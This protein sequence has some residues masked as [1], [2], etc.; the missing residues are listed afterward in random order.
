[1]ASFIGAGFFTD[2]SLCADRGYPSI[3]VRPK[4]QKPHLLFG[5]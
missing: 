4:T 3:K 1:M 2:L 5:K